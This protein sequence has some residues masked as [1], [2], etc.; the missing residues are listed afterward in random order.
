MGACA[1]VK[2]PCEML[3]KGKVIAEYNIILITCAKMPR[4]SQLRIKRRHGPA[5]PKPNPSKIASMSTPKKQ[6]KAK[7]QP[8][9]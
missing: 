1:H 6:H 3:S 5:K 8:Y 7:F 9:K 2:K 4:V